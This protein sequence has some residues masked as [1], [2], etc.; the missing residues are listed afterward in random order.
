MEKF[1][2]PD[3]ICFD[4]IQQK[5]KTMIDSINIEGCVIGVHE[6]TLL[7]A[8]ISANHDQDLNQALALVDI[9]A[10]AGW[11]CVKLQ[12]YDVESLTLRSTHSS[13]KIDPV[14]GTDNLYDLYNS[15]QMPMDFHQPL[16]EHAKKRGLLPFTTVYDP[17]D[18][19]FVQGLGCALYKISSFELTFDDLLAGVASTGKPV[20]L[21]TGMANLNEIDHALEILESNGSGPV[22]LLHC[23]SAYPAPVESVNLSAMDTL[24]NHFKRLVGFSDHTIGSRVPII[25]AAMGAVA[26]EKHVTND[27][28]R[29]G[30]D[31][32]FSSSPE[33]M[34]EIAQGVRTAH[35]TRGNGI[36]DVQAVE[37]SNKLIGRRSAFALRDLPAGHRIEEQDFRFVRPCAGIPVEYKTKLVGKQLVRAVKAY[38]PITFEDVGY[39]N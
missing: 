26:I 10:D 39:E 25:A 29:V 38:Y 16:F 22:I 2:S 21:S 34:A 4:L 1:D 30:P 33:I 9:V 24:R 23:C 20:I 37:Q 3:Y 5:T 28:H 14:W 27:P 12:T 32:R 18:L 36:K 19:D 15:A 7:V 13:M 11:D 6:P 35:L 31:H 17:K 8:E